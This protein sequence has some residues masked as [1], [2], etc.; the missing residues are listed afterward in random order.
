MPF[1]NLKI[2]I[3]VECDP[4]FFPEI[5]RTSNYFFKCNS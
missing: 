3:K 5:L 2:K 1:V 4:Q